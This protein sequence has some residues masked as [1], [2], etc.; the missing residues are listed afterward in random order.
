LLT[1]AGKTARFW[2]VETR[3]ELRRFEG[4]SDAVNLAVFAPDGRR[5][6]TGSED[7]TAKPEDAED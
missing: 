7:R 3:K 6:F 5:L 4:F 2:D 1:G